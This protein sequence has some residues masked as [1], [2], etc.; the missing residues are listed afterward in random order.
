MGSRKCKE[1]AMNNRASV[2]YGD[3][4]G[5]GYVTLYGRLI[6]LKRGYKEMFPTLWRLF[7]DG[8]NDPRFVMFRLNIERIEFA[9]HRYGFDSTRN[10]W[11]PFVLH[12]VD[13]TRLSET[14]EWEMKPCPDNKMT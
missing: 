5:M 11:R 4:D 14:A 8:P 10:D 2:T 12:R 9:S 1:I 7:L 3:I 6:E 13:G